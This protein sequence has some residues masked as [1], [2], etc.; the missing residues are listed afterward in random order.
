MAWTTRHTRTTA[1]SRSPGAEDRDPSAPEASWLPPHPAAVHGHD[2][3]VHVAG[4]VAR[5][6]D[7]R[8]GEV[9]RLAPATRG[10]TRENLFA[11]H[12]IRP[13]RR[14]VV[15]RD[16]AGRDRV[17]VD[18]LARPLVRERHREARDAALAGGV[19]G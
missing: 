14:R 15:G 13:Q 18:A 19:P 4:G 5:E 17:H 12:R 7:A 3:A 9:L 2:R 11:T 6:V 8:A 16:V 10:D 1:S